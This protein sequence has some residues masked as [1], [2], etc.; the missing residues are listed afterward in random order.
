MIS[1]VLKYWNSVIEIG[2]S[3]SNDNSVNKKIRIVNT[4]S[5]ITILTYF[6]WGI[7]FSFDGIGITSLETFLAALIILPVLFIN[8]FGHYTFAKY[9]SYI[10]SCMILTYFGIAHGSIDGVEYYLMVAAIVGLMYFDKTLQL[11][12]VILFNISCFWVIKYSHTVME[13]LVVSGHDLYAINLINTFIVIFIIA[14]YFKRENHYQEG[15]LNL[16]NE[17]LA[18]EKEKSENLLLN[19]LPEE[20]AEELKSTGTTVP[21]QFEMASVIFTDFR[22]FT[23]LSQVMS[24][25]DLV[26]EINE[27]FTAFDGIINKYNIEK[28]KTIGDAYMCVGGIPVP[29]QT[30]PI[31]TVMAALEFQDYVQERKERSI[32]DQKPYFDLRIGIHTGPVIAGVVGKSKFAYDIWGDTVNTA[33]RLESTCEVGKINISQFTYEHIKDRFNVH[34]RGK[35]EAKHK[36]LIDMYYVESII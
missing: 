10:G 6:G 12:I 23:R 31:D 22:E 5:T 7:S 14:H 1:I 21:K 32:Q 24:P 19:I 35:I 11:A 20:V 29:N 15:L 13:P 26:N 33:A 16:Q 34:P 8:Y 28:I 17:V 3:T 18:S 4:I 27:Y 2:T 36:G 25:I 30:N 9:Y